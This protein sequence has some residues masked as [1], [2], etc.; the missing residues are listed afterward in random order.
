[1]SAPSA[2]EE[3]FDLL[4][5]ILQDW[6]EDPVKAE[7]G[8]TYSR[9]G[10]GAWFVSLEHR[11]QPIT[12]PFTRAEMGKKLVPDPDA[13]EKVKAFRNKSINPGYGV[14]L[15]KLLGTTASIHDLRE[16]FATLDPL[17]DILDSSL[18]G[19]QPPQL[20]MIGEESTGKS[21]VLE[22]LAM[23]AIFPRDD[24]ICTRMPVH[25]R[26]RF[27]ERS[28]AAKLEVY[29]KRTK[30]TEGEAIVIPTETGAIDV[31]H[32]M[33]EIVKQ[34]NDGNVNGLGLDRIIILTVE[35]P[36]VPSIDLIDLP[37]LVTSPPE[38]EERTRK[39][40][41]EHI[42]EHGRYSMFL[43]TVPAND[44]PNTS[45]A[46]KVV[47]HHK[48]HGKTIGV[49]T[50][51][52]EVSVRLR[53]KLLKRLQQ[54]DGEADEASGM[55]LLEP[56]GWV[57][58]M[59]KEADV[60]EQKRNLARLARQARDED[61]FVH[62]Q[63]SDVADRAGCG[64]LIGKL[65]SLFKEF[66]RRDWGPRTVRMLGKALDAAELENAV[67]GMPPFADAGVPDDIARA[68]QLACS[69]AKVRISRA[70]NDILEGCNRDVLLPFK[71]RLEKD[72]LSKPMKNIP[73]SQM[74]AEWWKKQ[75]AMVEAKSDEAAD[76]WEKHWVDRLR[77]VLDRRT[78]APPSTGA[79]G[80]KER[81]ERIAGPSFE[82]YRFPALI[83]AIIAR[84]EEI[85]VPAKASI[86]E[87]VR[88][89]T[90]QY[91]DE[92]SPWVK[93]K[94]DLAASP[95]T[96]TV[97]G[98]TGQ[99]VN[100]IL[101][102]FILQSTS[103]ILG[104]LPKAVGEIASQMGDEAWVE[105]C[106]EERH[107][108]RSRIKDL[109]NGMEQILGLFGAEEGSLRC[110]RVVPCDACRLTDKVATTAHGI[111]VC[112]DGRIFAPGYH[113]NTV[114]V[115]DF[116]VNREGS[117]EH[118]WTFGEGGQLSNP[119]GIAID[120]VDGT[121]YVSSY[122][123]SQVVKFDREGNFQSA[124]K[125]GISN[126]WGVAVDEDH[127]YVAAYG[128]N[129]V[130]MYTKTGGAQVRQFG[131]TQPQG[132]AVDDGRVYVVSCGEHR[133]RVFD[134]ANGNEVLHV[135]SGPGSG[136]GH[137]YNPTDV[138]IFGDHLYVSSQSHSVQIFSKADGTFV[139]K[140]GNY[141]HGDAPGQL[142]TPYG[143]CVDGEGKLV[144]A[145]H[146]RIEI[147]EVP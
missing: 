114:S 7:D 113:D 103:T 27:S 109:R 98:E 88:R 78:P 22:R 134:T 142:H 46:M 130:Y 3:V 33:Q 90:D 40:V 74:T 57:G 10:I 50:M 138:D 59:N 14:D 131:V 71:E 38:N 29:N 55:V 35:S 70:A 54:S 53:P 41:E 39:L 143:V 66:L 11:Q 73:L 112:A 117:Q 137:L 104:Q 99:L 141:A 6:L 119:N 52:D 136:D 96:C 25:V 61:V 111:A 67:M 2:E 87:A 8:Y 101:M 47:E 17:R 64:A 13:A 121:V 135:G 115:Y 36:F 81:K 127:V 34:E 144:V 19:W 93:I 26:L 123:N 122:G 5:P 140:V 43:A 85:L 108:L 116:T 16:I 75:R 37:G 86:K 31:R 20:V 82:L 120:D 56:H 105:S 23:M 72:I 28:S 107:Q 100:H 69:D 60:G 92:M 139:R 62:N 24:E 21:T 128:S 45:S 94:T 89:C 145:C 97:T 65:N 79:A 80:A 32:K 146:Q 4:C 30:A 106:A 63:M 49:F 48:L 83:G 9:E 102:R 118:V 15:K 110:A 18:E 12:S 51:C 84:L 147:F 58:V 126:P 125:T 76:A 68:K 95:P 77:E 91:Y 124:F 129:C 44:A 132:I 42:K 1:M 133:V